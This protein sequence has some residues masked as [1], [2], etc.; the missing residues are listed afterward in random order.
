MGYGGGDSFL[1]LLA[2]KLSH[3]SHVQLSYGSHNGL[4]SWQLLLLLLLIIIIITKSLNHAVLTDFSRSDL[5][6][7]AIFV[8]FG[9]AY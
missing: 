6:D 9:C 2:K 4:I 8:I 1:S 3:L 5:V 7:F